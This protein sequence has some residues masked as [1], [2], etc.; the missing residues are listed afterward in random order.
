MCIR[1]S[2]YAQLWKGI[3]LQD[4]NSIKNASIELGAE[5]EY[6][7]FVSMITSKA[8]KDVM[9]KEEKD[10]KKRLLVQ[11]GSEDTEQLGEYVVNYH[12]EI[13]NVLSKINQDL[14]LLFKVNDFLRSLD[15]RL[16]SPVNTFKITADFC[17][18]TIYDEER[19]QNKSLWND[20][21]Y[22]AILFRARFRI[23]LLDIFLRMHKM[24]TGKQYVL[25]M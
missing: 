1:D 12:K 10:S 14:L 9:N 8:Y 18:Q 13:V 23:V 19:K 22:V 16:G 2:Y 24:V 7:L 11:K 4:E 3:I 5:Y 15:G 21:R 6:P 20:I 25:Q 17:V